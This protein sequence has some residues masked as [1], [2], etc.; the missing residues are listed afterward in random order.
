VAAT[1]LCAG[2]KK[3]MNLKKIALIFG[4]VLVLAAIVGFTVYQ[5]QKNV[6]AVQT[7]RVQK[8][9]L[10]S[11]VSGSGE[12]KPKTFTNVGALAFGQITRLYVHEGDHVKR[13]Q[14]LAQVDNTQP[15]AN[16]AA[17]RAGV[18][19]S[20]TDAVAAD[21]GYKTAVADLARAKADEQQKRLDYERAKGLYDQQLIAK[22]DF[23]AKDAAYQASASGLQQAEARIAQTRAQMESANQRISQASAQ[24]TATSDVLHKTSYV[25]P[26]DGVVTSLPVREGETVVMG[27]QNAPGSTLMTVADMSV[28]TAEIKVDE[29]DIINVRM[30]Q[31]AEV[32]IDA[33]PGQKFKAHVTEIGNN[34]MLRSTGVST[35]QSNSASE[36]AKDFKVVVTLENPPENL[37]PGLS[38]TAKITTATR[39]NALTIPIQALTVRNKKELEAKP[40][41]DA[42]Q[43]AAPPSKAKEED[44][45]GVFVIRNKKAVFIP[46]KTGI[47]G[48]TDI[49]VT[50]G[51]KDGDE[52][53]SGSYRVLRTLRNNASVKI[54]NSSPTKDENK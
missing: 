9:D 26:Y 32:T 41:S 14:P 46:V 25:A 38:A 30:G 40:A 47:A 10:N 34:A 43:A 2:K 15:T 29:T 21:A 8:G 20:R 18:Q 28:V 54:D 19:A 16:V 37:R 52:I 51:L 6:V 35:S 49:E 23:D 27:I 48:T 7:A 50:D 31:P 17:G 4:V 5:S 22:A 36:E 1:L 45:Q 44:Q 13:G 12:I 33:V 39:Q 11:V 24:L 3:P 53:V 42:V